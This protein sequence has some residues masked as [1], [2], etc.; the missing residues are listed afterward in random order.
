MHGLVA[1]YV[2]WVWYTRLMVWPALCL[3]A[4][5]GILVVALDI[6]LHSEIDRWR[7]GKVS[8][9]AQNRS[10]TDALEAWLVWIVCFS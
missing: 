1:E 10:T 6:L 3:I 8:R 9:E 4:G 7:A 5:Q 2:R